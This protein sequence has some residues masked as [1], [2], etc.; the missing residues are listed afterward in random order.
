MMNLKNLNKHVF[1]LLTMDEFLIQEQLR[2]YRAITPYNPCVTAL[3]S[4]TPEATCLEEGSRIVGAYA[5]KV[6][7]DLE[8]LTDAT[9]IADA[10]TAG[11]LKP[12]KGLAGNWVLGTS[13]KKPGM[14]FNKEKHSSFTYAIPL[15]HYSVDA[16][17]VFW[18]TLDKQ[19]GWSILFVFEDLAIWGA[20]T[21][22][23]KLV[24][25]DIVMGPSSTDELGGTRQF[26]GT[27]GWTVDS[28]PYALT[29]PVIGGFTKAN[30]ST[31]FK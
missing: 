16:N 30:L 21:S 28:L 20:L 10:I 27:I 8:T 23:K 22:D 5:A 17:L 19:V 29:S 4:F 2:D 6:T 3:G 11:D 9:E 25:M 26:E 7:L 14:G 18:N 1:P 12:I 15:K 24:P 13:N 31:Q